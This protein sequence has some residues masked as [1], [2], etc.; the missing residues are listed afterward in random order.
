MKVGDSSDLNLNLVLQLTM[1]GLQVSHTPFS[2]PQFS[3][4]QMSRMNKGLERID[5]PDLGWLSP[6]TKVQW[7]IKEPQQG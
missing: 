2:G 6:R 4:L 3:H 5:T 7:P 1:V